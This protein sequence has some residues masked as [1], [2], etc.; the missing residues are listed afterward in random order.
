MAGR[1]KAGDLRIRLTLMRPTEE[2]DTGR[3]RGVV[4]EDAAEVA[5]AKADVSGREFYAAHA[6]HAEDVVTWTIRYRTDVTTAWRCREGSGADGTVYDILEVN[7]LGYM[8]DY[9]RL[10]C[11]AVRP[12]GR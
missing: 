8:Q 9:I 1:I 5:A 6:V 4:F 2:R 12:G 10:K 7:H 3:A 11:R